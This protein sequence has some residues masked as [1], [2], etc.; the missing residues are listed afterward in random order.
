[1]YASTEHA[2]QYSPLLRRS[3]R[4]VGGGE[5]GRAPTEDIGT[6]GLRALRRRLC[7]VRIRRLAQP[8]LPSR[9]ADDLDPRAQSEL[10][11]DAPL[12]R[13]DGLHTQAELAGDLLVAEAARNP[14][15]H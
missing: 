14:Q 5:S 8:A 12:V 10:L 4:T 9:V 6:S 3:S 2:L 11:G 7:G 13:L 1:M 15:Q